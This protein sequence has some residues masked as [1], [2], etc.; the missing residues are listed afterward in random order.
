MDQ[1]MVGVSHLPAVQPGDEV[2]LVGAQGEAVLSAE[3]VAQTWGTIN[4][5]VTTGIT[6]RVPRLYN[7]Y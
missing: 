5:E 3:A 4:Y 6:A 1:I 2:V 7:F